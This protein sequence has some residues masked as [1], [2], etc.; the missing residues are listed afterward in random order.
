MSRAGAI[1]TSFNAGELSP[2]LHGRVDTQVYRDGLAQMEGWLPTVQGPAVTAPGTIYVETAPG[3]FRCLP[4][5]YDVTQGYVIEASA[6]LFRFYTNDVLLTGADVVSPYT[7]PQIRALDYQQSADVLYL[8]HPQMQ[9]RK[10]VRTGASS[11]ALQLLSFD[12]GPFDDGNADQGKTIAA[13]GTTGSVTLTANVPLFDAGDVGGLIELEAG[14]FAT[15]RMWEPGLTVAT[16]D[17]RAWAGRVYQAASGGAGRTGTVPPTH[18]QGA[19]WDGAGTGTD[20]NGKNAGG[21]P[22]TFLYNRF[23]RL[24]ITA[25]ASATSATATVLQRL[26]DG[27]ANWRWAFGAFS[28]RRGWPAAGTLWRERHVLAKGAT[29][30]GSVVGGYESWQARDSSGDFQRDLAFR[31]TLPNPDRVLWLAADRQLVVGTARAEHAVEQVDV[32]S[33]SA[34]PPVL[35]AATQSTYGAA[36]VKPVLAQGRVLFVQR[37]GRKLMEMGYAIESDR[38]EAPDILARAE[39]L[40]AAGLIEL[41]WQSEPER[42]LWAVRGD[43][44]LAAM[45]YERGQQVA[46]WARR[47]LGGG[48]KA[49]TACAID[50]PD[51]RAQQLW[52]GVETA[53]GQWWMLRMAKLWETGDAQA[54]AWLVDAGLSYSGAA[55]S[56]GGGLAHLAVRTCQVLADGKPHRDITIGAGG[57]WALDYPASTVTIGLAFPAALTTLPIEAGGEDGTAQGKIKRI[58]SVT[59]RLLEAQGLRIS[60]D[61]DDA[62]PQEFRVPG[63]QMDRAVPLLSG[64]VQVTTVGLHERQGAI[65]I[66]R[67]QPTPATLLAIMPVVSTGSR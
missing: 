48:L 24:R 14:D 41:A 56:S 38:Y 55:V 44:S 21:V 8:Y 11:F 67:F 52:L 17:L 62:T 12:D 22:W 33:G 57:G 18:D 42:H 6:G 59:L 34:G 39:H 27:A 35:N 40:G 29:L 30:Y 13:S 45:T 7:L 47:T 60:V 9:T 53:A 20:I 46:G 49:R 26:A 15:V 16:G 66:E 36:G 58:P 5:E 63:D 54:G 65:T 50:A 37:A 4:F 3:P 32:Q 2:R 25:V 19:E 23:G 1:Q 51:G 43:G 64:D 31:A 61:G 28:E 10:L